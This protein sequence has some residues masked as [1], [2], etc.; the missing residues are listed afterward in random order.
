MNTINNYEIEKKN[1]FA[2]ENESCFF[3]NI[4]MC[5]LTN[6]FLHYMNNNKK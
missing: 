3:F 5:T 2:V 1:V 6:C 4:P